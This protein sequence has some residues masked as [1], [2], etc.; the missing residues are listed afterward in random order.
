[1]INRLCFNQDTDFS[2]HQQIEDE[3]D[4]I[5]YYSLPDQ[6]LSRLRYFKKSLEKNIKL[7]LINDVIVIGIGGSSLGAKA[8]YD[9][10]KS[11]KRNLRAMHFIDSTDPNTISSICSKINFKNSFFFVISKSGTTIETIA[12][13]KYILNKFKKY[14]NFNNHFAIITD[15]NTSLD[16]YA[17]SS[18]ILCINSEENVGG[19]FSVLSSSGIIPLWLC[20]IDILKILRG[21]RSIKNDFFYKR[22]I[23]KIIHSKAAFYSKYVQKY[24][25]NAVFS[26]SDSLESFND[27]YIQLWGE[28]LGKKTINE[29]IPTG[30]T[31]VGLIGPKDQHSFLQLISEGPRDKTISFIK[32]TNYE[33]R[34]KIPN[35]SLAFNQELDSLHGLR[36]SKL[37]NMQADS[38]IE[39]LKDFNEIP[40]DEIIISE[41]NEYCIGQLIFYFQLL[42]SIV[43]KHLKINTYDQPG[44]E[45]GKSILMRYLK[46]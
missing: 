24:N 42:T 10:I 35:V 44:V 1:M 22:D 14:S 26:Y 27:W 3:L 34:Y 19:R 43:G 5:G 36:F 4:H 33:N 40:L 16:K 25:I 7:K 2:I 11:R 29:G 38:I 30:L 15:P 8:I 9:F 37:I 31:P 45:S 21:A 17:K 18:G 28:S 12:S 46:K 39:S 41:Q 6:D 13:Y 20:G 23:Y 32:I